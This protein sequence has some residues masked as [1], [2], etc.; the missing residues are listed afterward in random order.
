MKISFNIFLFFSLSTIVFGQD[1]VHNFGNIQVH[2]NGEVGFHMDIIN[3]GSFNQNMGLVGFYS[4]DELTISGNSNP[5][6]FDS[7]VAI[8]NNLFL[9][10]TVGIRNNFNFIMGDMV[11]PRDASEI[12]INFIGDAFYNGENDDA[13]INGYASITNRSEFVF[14]VG[15]EGRLR[16]LQ[17]VSATNNSYAKCAYFYEDPN[18]PS[19]FSESFDTSLV[20]SE[21]LTISTSEFWHLESDE[22]SSVTLSWDS[23]SFISLFAESIEELRVVGWNTIQRQWVD[24]GNTFSDGNLNQGTIISEEFRPD[25]FTIITLGG[26]SDARS[27]LSTVQLDN[28]YMTPNGDGINDVLEIEGLENS[29]NNTLQIFKPIWGYGIFKEKL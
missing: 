25:D 18:I 14:P 3:D 17:I 6:F 4:E 12:N 16:T 7:E 22:S 20:A 21:S 5:V 8:T 9:E 2:N 23:S 13:K 11:T 10:N 28:Y 24:L 1:A 26:N 19:T 15:E 29:P 27:P